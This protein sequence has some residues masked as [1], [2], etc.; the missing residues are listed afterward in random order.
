MRQSLAIAT[1]SGLV[2]GCSLIFDPNNLGKP[3]DGPPPII[4]APV[5]VEVIMPANPS[6]IAVASIYPPT[7]DEGRGDHMSRPA[8]LVLNGSNFTTLADHLTATFALMG[9]D[10]MTG[11]GSGILTIDSI[12]VG[13]DHDWI[14]LG[15]RVPVDKNCHEGQHYEFSVS[16]SEDDG[17]GGS[18]KA[19]LSDPFVLTCHD[20]L[21]GAWTGS[22]TLSE[23]KLWS[24]VALTGSPTFAT[25]GGSAFI[26]SASTITVAGTMTAN[27]GTSA[28]GPGGQPGGAA[29]AT[30]GGA[31]GGAAGAL[32]MAGGGGGFE[33]VGGMGGSQTNGG[34]VV[35][36]QEIMTFTGNFASGGGGGAA[37]GPVLGGAGGGGGGT[38]ALFAYGDITLG[39]TITA[40]GGP[41]ASSTEGG[42]GGAGGLVVVRTQ[43]T[44]SGL[45]TVNVVGGQGMSGG[46]AGGNGRARFD[47]AM[48]GQSI[49]TTD[50][51][52]GTYYGP[53]PLDAPLI[54][55]TQTPMIGAVGQ[56]FTTAM[57]QVENQNKSEPIRPFSVPF[58]T[59]I[60]S[61]VMGV[62]PVP[63]TVGYNLV[64]MTVPA[65]DLQ[66]QEVS[67]NC[68]EM[69]FL[70]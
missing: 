15:V 10:A 67:S 48:F 12:D 37:V 65:G 42:G 66:H 6:N 4:D 57:G 31:G 3:A 1:M 55:H 60:P 17:M 41:G 33:T 70:P 34:G 62:G 2:G 56:G 58:S 16:V 51:G 14:A 39:G 49:A 68:V 28:A 25:G 11:S 53:M 36:E 40:N 20:E 35:G 9:S 50:A 19:M 23:T 64:C 45:T 8:L 47:A 52:S 13:A 18:A 22:A 7:V 44:L 43:G 29:G 59:T 63:L 69:A 27:G 32:L 21:D 5:D 46:G 61:T 24:E 38:I 54:T 26:Y 30:G